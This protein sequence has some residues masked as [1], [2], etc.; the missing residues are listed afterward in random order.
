[1]VGGEGW[2]SDYSE[3]AFLKIL[4]ET[5]K[6]TMAEIRGAGKLLN[7]VEETHAVHGDRDLS[8]W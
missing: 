8:R 5:H 3:R 7:P 1:M 2:S 4:D 6:M